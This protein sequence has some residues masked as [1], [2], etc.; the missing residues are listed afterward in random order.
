MGWRRFNS[1]SNNSKSKVHPIINHDDYFIICGKKTFVI[2]Q[3]DDISYNAYNFISIDFNGDT[4]I[5]IFETNMNLLKMI[6][7]NL[8]CDLEYQRYFQINSI[9]KNNK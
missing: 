2:K 3:I 7:E 1:L 4:E 9:L 5:S 8:A 6:R